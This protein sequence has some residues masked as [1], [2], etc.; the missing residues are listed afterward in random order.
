MARQVAQGMGYL[1]AKGIVLRK[2]NSRNVYLD[3]KVKL[4]LMDYG[5]AD[6]RLDRFVAEHAFGSDS[7]SAAIFKISMLFPTLSSVPVHVPIS[8]YF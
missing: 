5:M 7:Y 2:L 1:H 3:H 8:S 6:K 4:C